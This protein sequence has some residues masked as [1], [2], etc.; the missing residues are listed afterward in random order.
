MKR[1]WAWLLGISLI[2][3]GL[4]TPVHGD[5]TSQEVKDLLDRYGKEELIWAVLKLRNN[6][7]TV[8]VRGKFREFT[9]PPSPEFVTVETLMRDLNKASVDAERL[10]SIISPAAEPMPRQPRR[11]SSKPPTPVPALSGKNLLW[12][13]QTDNNSV[14]L[15]GSLHLLRADSYPLSRAI[16]EA[17]DECEKIVF[18]TDVGEMNSPATLKRMMMLGLYSGDETL[19]NQISDETYREFQEKITHLGLPMAQFGRFRPWLCA[20]TIVG[21]ELFRLGFD[22]N[23]GLDRYFFNRAK[24]Q[25]KERIFLE[26]VD[27]QL[28]IFSN[29]NEHEQESLLRQTLK[30][31]EIIEKMANEMVIAWKKGD[32]EELGAILQM[33]FKDYPELYDRFVVQR[34]RAWLKEIE[35]LLNQG[36]DVLVVVGAGHL[37]GS[38]SLIALLRSKGHEVVQR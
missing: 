24:Q 37:V 3:S 5:V 20:V 4:S 17:Y 16:M 25:G 8:K 38:E 13:V 33:S 36:E 2:L 18:E 26:T 29:M 1:T 19:A 30:D 27:D 31:L 35:D 6:Q 32:A 15:L 23:Y 14:Y 7:I 9:G 21:L 22:P 12:S 34:N 11:A 10:E 28:A